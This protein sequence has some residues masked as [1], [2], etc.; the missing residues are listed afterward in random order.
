MTRNS[1][2]TYTH[3]PEPL[4]CW[5]ESG[6]AAGTP[7]TELVPSCLAASDSLQ[8]GTTSEPPHCKQTEYVERILTAAS[9]APAYM[10]Q[11]FINT[12]FY[13]VYWSNHRL[14]YMEHTGK[15][16]MTEFKFPSLTKCVVILFVV[17]GHLA[18]YCSDMTF[19]VHSDWALMNMSLSMSR[20]LVNRSFFGHSHVNDGCRE[21]HD[22]ISLKSWFIQIILIYRYRD[23]IAFP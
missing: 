10:W 8:S 9:K 21:V 12:H 13:C 11:Q 16:N 17:M 18:G 7:C 23:G 19:V 22:G 6:T 1:T 2:E 14:R 3:R 4:L 15:R 5:W 20:S